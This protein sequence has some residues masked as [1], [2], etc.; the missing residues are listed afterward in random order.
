MTPRAVCLDV[1]GTMFDLSVVRRG[2]EKLGAPPLALEVWFGRLLHAAAAVTLTGDFRPFPEL[3]HAT[4]RSVLAQLELD[5]ERAQDVLALLSQLE[6]YPETGAAL[7]RLADSRLRVVALTNGSEQNTRALLERSGLDRQVERIVATEAVGV[8]KPHRAV[9]E[10]AAAELE[11]PAADVTLI[12]AHAWDVIG[13]EAA[14][15]N[16]VWV[17]RLER[18]WP[19][20]T[21]EP[22]HAPDLGGAVEILLRR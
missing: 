9:Y 18:V 19:L 16:A 1:M 14:G 2:L 7:Q 13:A 11:V 21:R 10:H 5:P 12:A 22:R 8:Y 17:T 20:P 3:A 6:P 4:L 15:L